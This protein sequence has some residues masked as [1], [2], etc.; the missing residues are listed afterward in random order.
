MNKIVTGT[1]IELATNV[2]LF[3]LLSFAFEIISAAL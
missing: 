2:L 3:G 1:I